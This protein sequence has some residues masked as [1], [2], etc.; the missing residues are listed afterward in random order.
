MHAVSLA[1]SA[2]GEGYGVVVAM[3]GDGTANEVL[4]GLMRGREAGDGDAAMGVIAVGRGND[5]ADG[6]GVARG[7]EASC[8]VL[9]A[10]SM[11]AKSAEDFFRRADFSAMESGLVSTRWSDWKPRSSPGF[12][13]SPAISSPR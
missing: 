2:A 8:R 6:I 9:A 1:Q 13:G 7:V 10:G 11:W 12:P 3:G 4:N 5:F